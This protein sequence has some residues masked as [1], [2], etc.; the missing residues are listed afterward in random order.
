MKAV[1]MRRQVE[2]VSRPLERISSGRLFAR[3]CG[4]RQHSAKVFAGRCSEMLGM[5]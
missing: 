2:G 4:K 5:E 3:K 1:T